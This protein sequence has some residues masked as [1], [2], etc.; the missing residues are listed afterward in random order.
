VIDGLANIMITLTL[1][2]RLARH[3]GVA[4]WT[5]R[6]ATC[7]EDYQHPDGGGSPSHLS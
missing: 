7:N 4:H 2:A 1:I 5:Q 6:R 3:A